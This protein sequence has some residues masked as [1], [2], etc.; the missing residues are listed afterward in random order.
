MLVTY[1]YSNKNELCNN[2]R[3]ETINSYARHTETSMEFGQK[4][5]QVWRLYSNSKRGL[6]SYFGLICTSMH[7]G[8]NRQGKCTYCI[9]FRVIY[10]ENKNLKIWL[11]LSTVY[12][13]ILLGKLNFYWST[14]LAFCLRHVPHPRSAMLKPPWAA[15]YVDH[16]GQALHLSF[17]SR[18]FFSGRVC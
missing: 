11:Q 3:V 2:D 12:C 5:L 14:Y 18:S 4:L 15:A 6:N 17:S 1:I 9:W 16:F 10:E 13:K 8:W 7:M